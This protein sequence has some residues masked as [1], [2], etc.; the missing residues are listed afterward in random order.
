MNIRAGET[1]VAVATK[2]GEQINLHF[3]HADDFAIY[4]VSHE[5]VRYIETRQVEHYCQGGYGD[6][7]K[8]EVILRALSDCTALFAARVGGG[9][10]ARLAGA[11]IEPVEEYPFGVIEASIRDWFTKRGG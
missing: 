5:E 3:G 8:R 1:V 2:G 4:A 10:K 6:E 11:G 9:P 7:D